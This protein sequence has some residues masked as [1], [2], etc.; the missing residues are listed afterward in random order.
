MINPKPC[1]LSARERR[2]KIIQAMKWGREYTTI[3]LATKC[4]I[5]RKKASK[6]VGWLVSMGLLA[7]DRVD[8]V[9]VYRLKPQEAAE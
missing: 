7:T 5:D 3:D 2:R 8:M 1:R 4:Q 9:C 6:D